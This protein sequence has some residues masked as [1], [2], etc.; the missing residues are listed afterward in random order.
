MNFGPTLDAAVAK[1]KREL[2]EAGG[3]E[4]GPDLDGIMLRNAEVIAQS[5]PPSPELLEQLKG[6]GLVVFRIQ[7]KHK[8]FLIRAV[9]GPDAPFPRPDRT[10]TPPMLLLP[11]TWAVAVA[12]I[13]AGRAGEVASLYR[14]EISPVG[15]PTAP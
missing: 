11:P 15:P 4:S 8:G 7:A 9:P 5:V 12:L 1:V 2:R 14:Q 10:T 3:G 13:S 6:M